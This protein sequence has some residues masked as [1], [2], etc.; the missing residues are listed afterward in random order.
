MNRAPLSRLH[1]IATREILALPDFVYRASAIAQHG[2]VAI[3]IRGRGLEGTTL[4]N[5]AEE[6]MAA[7]P[8]A[9][10][11]INDRADVAKAVDAAGVHLPE[12]GLPTSAARTFLGETRWIGR[13]VHNPVDVPAAL[14]TGADY[15]FLGPIWP[16][17]SHPGT[18]GLGPQVLKEMRK[19]PVFAIGGVTPDNVGAAR[20]AGAYGVAAVRALWLARDPGSVARAMLLS[21]EREDDA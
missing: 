13:S 3:H 4:A 9:Q 12:A 10:L 21:L 2:P 20:E 18:P 17:A 15:L 14:E 6:V 11:L 1:A 16:T 19:G 8:S 5:A 7:A